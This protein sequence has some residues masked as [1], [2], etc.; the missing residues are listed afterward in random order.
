MNLEKK[1]EHLASERKENDEAQARQNRDRAVEVSA[2]QRD[3]FA[4]IRRKFKRFEDSRMRDSLRV[5]YGVCDC[6]ATIHLKE[7]LYSSMWTRI[8]PFRSEKSVFN[9]KPVGHRWKISAAIGD[10]DKI[11]WRREYIL[12]HRHHGS[13]RIVRNL[14]LELDEIE[15]WIA[16]IVV[17]EREESNGR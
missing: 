9:S 2:K 16:M 15:D 17:R 11:V 13:K 5:T 6:S 10:D 3:A 4:R 7:T 14:A 1:I 8:W 12:P